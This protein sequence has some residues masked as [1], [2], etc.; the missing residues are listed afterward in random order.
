MKK[1]LITAV[2]C[3]FLAGCQPKEIDT[4]NVRKVWKALTVKENGTLVYTEGNAANTRPGYS[5]FRLDLTVTDQVTFSDIDGRKLTGKWSLATDY[6]RLILENLTPPPSETSGNVEFYIVNSSETKLT[7][8]RTTES[9]KT[10]NTT[11]EYE[12][13][14]E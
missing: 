5:R 3:S 8:K 4:I 6:K 10:G 7:L 1:Y 9:R 11:N 12:L 14:P 13:V 2:L